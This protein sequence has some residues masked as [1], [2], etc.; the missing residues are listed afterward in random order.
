MEK[1]DNLEDKTESVIDIHPRITKIGVSS[2]NYSDSSTTTSEREFNNDLDGIS[3]AF[4]QEESELET[5][6]EIDEEE[7]DN[8][9]SEFLDETKSTI[10]VTKLGEES[11]RSSIKSLTSFT[12]T[13]SWKES[14]G[15]KTIT[16]SLSDSDLFLTRKR[17][18]AD[19]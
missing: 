19:Y 9:V 8:L 3:P 1:G 11:K 18:I 13:I 4:F 15:Q 6:E 10:E 16:R 7:F 12:P 5:E 17:K 2:R 14:E